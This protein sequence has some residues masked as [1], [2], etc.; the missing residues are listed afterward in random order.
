MLNTKRARK[1]RQ[2]KVEKAYNNYKLKPKLTVPN[3]IDAFITLCDYKPRSVIKLIDKFN[4][5]KISQAKYIGF[6]A[7]NQAD[8]AAKLAGIPTGY[9]TAQGIWLISKNNWKKLKKLGLE[10]ATKVD[11]EFKQG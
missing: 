10:V 8:L 11:D 9:K 3:K 5:I 7:G 2:L 6:L 4:S 1:Q